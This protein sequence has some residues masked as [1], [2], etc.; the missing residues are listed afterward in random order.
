MAT[1]A[2]TVL[3]TTLARVIT[4]KTLKMP[5]RI[6]ERLRKEYPGEWRYSHD[7]RAW[8][9]NQ[10]GRIVRCE[11]RSAMCCMDACDGY[12]SA[13]VMYYEQHGP[14]DE[15]RG[16]YVLPMKGETIFYDLMR[17]GHFE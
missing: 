6:I 11:A 13:Y 7:H 4:L 5:R 10:L 16:Q 9:D 14:P 1:L 15:A 2:R 12:T 17:S 8:V 3:G